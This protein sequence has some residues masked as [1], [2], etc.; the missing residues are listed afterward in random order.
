MSEYTRP[1]VEARQFRDESGAVIPYGSRWADL[2][3]DGSYS[4][5]SNAERFAP[6][7][8][9]ADALIEHL[10]ATYLTDVA[11]LEESAIAAVDAPATT[12]LIAVTPERVDAAPLLFRFTDFPGVVIQAGVRYS[13][14]FPICGCDACDETWGSVAA[15]ME[16]LVLAVRDGKFSERIVL[17]QQATG[18]ASFEHTIKG[19]GQRAGSGIQHG[20]LVDQELRADAARLDSLPDGLWQPWGRR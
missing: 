1:V 7:L 17:P 18:T 15:E 16:R 6:L 8:P 12:K 3:P 11:A 9:V 20:L 19:P 2:P 10:S 14:A 13:G 5:V 4:R